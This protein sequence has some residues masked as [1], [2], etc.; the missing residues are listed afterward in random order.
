M[1]V[2]LLAQTDYEPSMHHSCIGTHGA[3]LAV[4]PVADARRRAPAR[5]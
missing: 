3:W 2:F 5:C 1:Q 4:S